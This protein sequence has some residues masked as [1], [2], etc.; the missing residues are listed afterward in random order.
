[1]FDS[2]NSI[3]ASMV[4]AFVASGGC[5]SSCFLMRNIVYVLILRDLMCNNLLR[6]AEIPS[7]KWLTFEHLIVEI[8][9]KEY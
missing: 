8:F 1:M 4:D 7:I 5:W 9:Q 3:Y 2:D 6:A